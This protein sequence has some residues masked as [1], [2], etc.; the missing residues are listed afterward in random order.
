MEPSA[1][2]Q[3]ASNV[4]SG[5]AGLFVL[6]HTSKVWLLIGA[7]F[8]LVSMMAIAAMIA[9]ISAYNWV[10][11]EGNELKVQE[12]KRRLGNAIAMITLFFVLM[13]V[14]HYFVPDYSLLAL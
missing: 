8:I 10:N 11:A 3:I 5:L 2:A 4:T 13:S 7:R 14:Y 6:S 1:P 12:S 9:V